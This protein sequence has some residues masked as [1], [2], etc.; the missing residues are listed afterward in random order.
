MCLKGPKVKFWG[1]QDKMWWD[2]RI[3][4]LKGPCTCARIC[5]PCPLSGETCPLHVEESRSLSPLFSQCLRWGRINPI[6]LQATAV[7]LLPSLDPVTCK[8]IQWS[9][10][11]NCPQHD[12]WGQGG[13]PDIQ[14]L[15]CGSILLSW[16]QS[17]RNSW[18][19]KCFCSHPHLNG[20][21]LGQM[22]LQINS[23]RK[24]L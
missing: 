11:W 19:F 9:W 20:V 3:L 22:W 12:A 7:E 4:V 14:P 15:S 8:H 13:H 18:D 23:E 1:F 2:H 21:D 6:T 5:L 24:F 16:F 10:C 17:L